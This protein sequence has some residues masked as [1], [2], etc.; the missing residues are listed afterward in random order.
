MEDSHQQCLAQELLF[1]FVAHTHVWPVVASSAGKTLK[2]VQ[3]L[4][5]FGRI[6]RALAAAVGKVHPGSYV[7]KKVTMAQAFGIREGAGIGGARPSFRRPEAVEQCL[8][9][10]MTRWST[11]SG[12]TRDRHTG[13]W[14]FELTSEYFLILG[15]SGF[16]Q[17]DHATGAAPSQNNAASSSRR[18]H[19]KAMSLGEDQCDW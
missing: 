13:A 15:V 12:Q 7:G 9:Q 16:G 8:F 1:D 10:R 3:L 4:D 5:S 11:S 17:L 2:M 14:D 19:P 6:I 18:S